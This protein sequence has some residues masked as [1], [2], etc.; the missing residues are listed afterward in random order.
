[1]NQLKYI[2]G[3]WH[4]DICTT[5]VLFAAL[6]AVSSMSSSAPPGGSSGGSVN[7]TLSDLGC[8]PGE[9]ARVTDVEEWDCDPG[10]TAVEEEAID[11]NGRLTTIEGQN[12]DSRVSAI[13][14]Q[15]LDS[16]LATV[17]NQSVTIDGRIGV[18]EGQE[19]DPRVSMLEGQNINNRISTVENQNLDVRVSGLEANDADNRLNIL[20]SQSLDTRVSGLEGFDLNNRTSELE[21]II[22]G[23]QAEIAF[24]K[25]GTCFDLESG[26]IAND[27]FFPGCEAGGDMMFAFH[28]GRSLPTVFFWN[29]MEADVAFLRGVP[30]D[31]VSEG[32]INAL[33]FADH[34]NDQNYPLNLDVSFGATDS[35]IVYTGD[36]NYFKIGYAICQI[37]GS[38]VSSYPDCV[39]TNSGSTFGVRFKYKKLNVE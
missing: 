8:A 26:S 29:E 20:E 32:V 21:S 25:F 13:E 37:P 3:L 18:I 15:S 1:M 11:L 30:F 7:T 6:M 31:A 14:G 38:T 23:N 9:I 12:L 39:P 2:S 24:V 28:G 5:N 19:L 33:I 36:G 27:P 35:A 16:R 17:E 10:L 22:H 34:I 4:G